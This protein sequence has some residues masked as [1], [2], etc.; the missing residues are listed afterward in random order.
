MNQGQ[1]RDWSREPWIKQHVR[2]PLDDLLFP[3]MQRAVRQYL[4]TRAEID[5]SLIVDRDE[6][7]D[8]LVR[9]LGAHEPE[10]V[11]AREA[12]VELLRVGVLESDGRSIWMPERY[13]SQTRAPAPNDEEKAAPDAGP[14]PRQ[15]STAR[16]RA[17]R[18]RKRNERNGQP[19]SP[20][21]S[22]LPEALSQPVSVGVP[23]SVSASRGDRRQDPLNS[24]KEEKD[25]TNTL[26]HPENPRASDSVSP[27]SPEDDD[28]GDDDPPRGRRNRNEQRS[29]NEAERAQRPP[30]SS[31]AALQLDVATR[32]SLVVDRAELAERLRPEQ[33]SEVRAVAAA[34]ADARGCLTQPLGRYAQ[35]K[36][37]EQTVA[38][39]AAGYSQ[40]DLVHVVRAIARQP[41]AQGKG[42]GSLLT[43]KVVD[44]NRP[45]PLVKTE[46]TLSPNAAAV[47]ARV[48]Q[49]RT[50]RE[51][52]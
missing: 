35:D 3:L 46:A 19:A 48:R 10:A 32:A 44:A 37:V 45:K 25:Q 21:V 29:S 1:A 28:D 33:W 52:G 15:T 20:A 11:L 30:I 18:E 14:K 22:V 26:H 2:E 36:A 4:R 8:A 23:P 9:A 34:F 49:G 42:L 27:V 31:E 5:G 16:V 12:I 41:W 13:A 24:Q 17:H 6:P 40:A 50:T 47:L 51:A 38:L 39:Y 43:F 7:I